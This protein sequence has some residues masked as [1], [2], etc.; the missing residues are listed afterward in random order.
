TYMMIFPMVFAAF[1]PTPC[2]C[3]IS[4]F[5]FVDSRPTGFDFLIGQTPI[6][7]GNLDHTC[8]DATRMSILLIRTHL[9]LQIFKNTINRGL[10]SRTYR[11]II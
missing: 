3:F 8:S 11:D 9:S 5:S 2:S 6:L 7:I 4:V 10:N 1:L